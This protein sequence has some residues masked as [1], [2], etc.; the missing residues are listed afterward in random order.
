MEA[1]MKR[2]VPI[3]FALMFALHVPTTEAQSTPRKDI[4]AI[5]KAAN[6]AIVSI[7][8]SDK[9]GNPLA[10]GSGF[11]VSKDGLVL[12]NYHV[13]A[14]GS[15]A[16]VKLPD[17]AFYVVDGMVAS[18][19]ARDVAVIKTHGTNFRTLTLGNS[20]QIEVGEE[21]VA[22]GNP[23]SLESTVS[24]GIVSGIRTAEELGSKFLQV[25]VPISP[26][27]SGGPLFNMEGEVVGIT[28]LYLKGGENLNFAIPINDAK[29]LLLIDSSKVHEFPNETEPLE[30]QT[31][32]ADSPAQQPNPQ[33]Q[34][35]GLIPPEVVR[36]EGVQIE[37]GVKTLTVGNAHQIY[38]LSCN[39]TLDSCLTPTPDKDYLV[40]LKTTRWQMPRA[41]VPLTLKFLQDWSVAYNNQENIALFPADTDTDSSFGMYV[42]LSVASASPET[43]RDYFNELKATNVL[44]EYR[45]EYVCF[46]DINVPSFAV[47]A[48]LADVIQMMKKAGAT[49][50]AK[51]LEQPEF[52]DSLVV[53]KYYKGVGAGEHFYDAIG[54]EGTAF[55]LVTKSPLNVKEIYSIN[56]ATGHFHDMVYALD[57]DKTVPAI[58]YFGK[59][60]LI[61]PDV[62][63]PHR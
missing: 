35:A 36:S 4:P 26:G 50:M 9:D 5:A 23:M 62:P 59:C 6:G 43:A 1:V 16:L 18:D 20:D 54:T 44:N 22:I 11:L 29:R 41:K 46:N 17:G 8:M 40:F 27:S 28:T 42:L 34:N 47:V 21:V 60:E 49:A 14:E 53:Q 13:I 39:A 48:K 31:H 33:Q 25:T 57:Q 24:N 15:S 30:A 61:H 56:W 58:D 2:A 55:M 7:V 19:K 52:K 63:M 45:D 32:D 37:S 12:T 10:Q 51:K 38:H 3:A